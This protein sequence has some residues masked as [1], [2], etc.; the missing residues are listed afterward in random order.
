MFRIAV[1]RT[2]IKSLC[3]SRAR[4]L[5]TS[6]VRRNVLQDLYLRE[7]KNIKLAP[8]TPKDAEGSVKPWE[9][10]SKPKVPELEAQG[11]E[12]LQ[13]YKSEPVETLS[14]S[15]DGQVEEP[16]EEDWLVLDDAEEVSYH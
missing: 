1:Q 5:S 8:I 15:A 9:E 11:T 3:A 13:A 2:A 12:A 16:V 4:L 7:L 10:P 6:A 14:E